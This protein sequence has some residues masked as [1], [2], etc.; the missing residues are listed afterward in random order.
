METPAPV[1]WDTP[2][3]EPP[4]KPRRD[5]SFVPDLIIF[6][7]A[8]AVGASLVV[9]AFWGIAGWVAAQQMGCMPS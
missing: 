1:N 5:L 8:L 4:A 2:A 9:V 7:L 6:A 3:E